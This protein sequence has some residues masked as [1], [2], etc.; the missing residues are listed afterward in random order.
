MMSE[1]GA[2]LFLCPHNAAKSVLAAA[3][4]DRLARQRGL[5]YRADSAGTE[6]EAAASP[7]VIAALAEEGID[8]ARHRPRLVTPE[9]LVAA[10]WIVTFG[11]DLGAGAPAGIPI[12]TW[13]DVPPASRDLE[14]AQRAIRQHVE[15]LV[16]ELVTEQGWPEHDTGEGA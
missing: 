12:E 15:Q 1:S 5:P 11:C 7:A 13:D 4:F 14:R 6:P 16:A 2:V 3:Y 9:D 10:R 8:V